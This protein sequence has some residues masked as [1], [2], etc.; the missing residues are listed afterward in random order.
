MPPEGLTRAAYF[1]AAFELLAERG[2]DGLTIAALCQRL[3]VTKGSFYH[4]FADFEGF[5]DGLLE[6]WAA[7][8]ATRLIA[9]S[10]SMTD[11]QERMDLLRGI[12]VGL[13]HGAEAAIRAWSWSNERVAAVQRDVDRARLAHLTAATIDTGS[14]PERARLLATIALST[15]IGLQQL[16]RPARPKAMEEVF[17]ELERWVL[18]SKA[19][20]G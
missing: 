15:L 11:P 17:G 5:V 19:V 2:Q 13:P 3:G 18:E 9:L 6:H 1:D 14:D 12:A 7:E 10:E 4:H 16:E 8:H 20:A